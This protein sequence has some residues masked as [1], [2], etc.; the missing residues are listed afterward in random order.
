MLKYRFHIATVLIL[1]VVAMV[2]YRNSGRSTLGHKDVAIAVT[3]TDRVTA[4]T[5]TGS[6]SEVSLVRENDS[7]WYLNSG[8][9]PSESAVKL[10]VQTLARLRIS[11]PAPQSV[12]SL[13]N[14]DL[15]IDIHEGR[16]AR[17]IFVYSHGPGEPTYMR[18]SGDTRIWEVEV[19][20]FGGHVAS[21]F[22]A[23]EN[24]WRSNVLFGYK[25]AEIEEVIVVY[26][27]EAEKSF[28]L[29]QSADRQ[30]SLFRHP[31]D[32]QA[33]SVIDSIAARYLSGFMHV[34][35]ERFAGSG[36]K[37][38]LDS[39]RN[40][41]PDYLISVKGRNGEVTRASLHRI[42]TGTSG[43]D[44]NPGFDV[45]R[46]HAVVNEG[47]D[48]VIVA[49]HMVDLLLRSYSYFYHDKK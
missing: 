11:G 25:P 29:R 3:N 43:T 22:V 47:D 44:G 26:P 9:E 18:R 40:A 21:L 28:I 42:L 36:E 39:L 6:A 14:D 41:G 37:L 38:L 17:S 48:M 33:E 31:D 45:F 2:L 1:L 15:R 32:G 20:G 35:F 27:G 8:F 24:Y 19:V 46:L 49:W 34:P 12:S 7:R 10:L 23:D 30:V 16:R 13:F 4:I 5:I